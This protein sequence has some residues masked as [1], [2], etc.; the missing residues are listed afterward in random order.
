[1]D[2][3]L[4]GDDEHQIMNHISVLKDETINQFNYL[5]DKG[6]VFVDGTLG[7]AGHSVAI[8]NN[9]NTAASL[10]IIGIDADES[11]LDR[12]KKIIFKRGFVENFILVHN[13][14][15][16]I[17]SILAE[18]N[19]EKIDGGLLDLG[20]SSMQFDTKERGFSFQ[21]PDQPLDM[22]MDTN[23]KLTTA[24]VLNSYPAEKITKIL[25]E[26]GEERFASRIIKNI[27]EARKKSPI[28]KVG[29]LLDVLEIS[30]P[31]FFQKRSKIHF[32]TKT[33]QALRIEV[34]G[35]LSGLDEAIK[36]FVSVLKPGAKLAIISFHS[37]EDR[38]V[39][40]TFHNLANPCHCPPKMPCVC[41]LKPSVKILTKKP[42]IPSESEISTNPR[43]RSAKLRVIEKI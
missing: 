9:Q 4:R 42:I 40:Q 35:E 16:N 6:G 24:M 33:F 32:A 11:A 34:N 5:K 18:L 2:P 41:N 36:D 43:S 19:I 22:R 7:L 3:R 15:K 1:M 27:V 26:Y 28:A 37:L 8:L 14:F 10:K 39:K 38:I 25:Y 17:K 12:A 13:N 23:Q 29:D 31:K 30:I 20:V 21:D